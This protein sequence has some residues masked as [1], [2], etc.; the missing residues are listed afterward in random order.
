LNIGWQFHVPKT[1]LHVIFSLTTYPAYRQPRRIDVNW[2]VAFC[3]FALLA[4]TIAG[5]AAAQTQPRILTLTES[6]DLAERQNLDLQAARVQR[7]VAL[8]GVRI[9]GQRPNPTAFFS[10]ARDTPH[11]SLF[12][13]QP[14]EIGGRRGKRIEVAKQESAATEASIIGLTRQL[15]RD[16]RVAYFTLAFAHGV[17]AQ[18]VEAAQL[19]A[20]LKEIAQA[21]FES[22]DIA[23]LEVTQA[24]LEFSRANAEAQAA[25]REE[26]IALSE[27]NVLLNAP[28]SASWDLAT[29][30]DGLPPLLNLESLQAKATDSNPEIVQLLQ[31]A[32]AEESRTGLLKAERI[33]NLGVEFGVDFNSPGQGGF[34]EGGRG[35]LSME[36][37]IFT[38]NQGEIAQSNAKL[39]ALQQET[40]AKRRAVAGR[41]EGAYYQLTSREAEVNLY[42]QTLVPSTKQLEDLAE[43]S[44]KSGKANI[45]TVLGAQRDVQQVESQYLNSLLAM[46]TSFADF[47]ETTGAPL[48]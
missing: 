30:L 26:E 35:Q 34:R 45:L 32:K 14:L 10:A 15:R 16:V 9:A 12:F 4:I 5:P 31:E 11:E 42:K 28:A 33:P 39:R 22:G 17:T 48:D 38:R 37:P 13:D 29:G 44:Y 20:R 36:L 43:E 47:E 18:K 27:L 46:Q 25:K 24:T 7:A 41:V 19:A 1:R 3:A 23:Q 8:A 6:F 2:R 40:A 21:R